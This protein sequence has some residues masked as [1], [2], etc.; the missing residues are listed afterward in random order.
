MRRW[1][2]V[3]A[4]VAFGIGAVLLGPGSYG[5]FGQ[6]SLSF[7]PNSAAAP[8]AR[9]SA[10]APVTPAP[11]RTTSPSCIHAGA[12]SRDNANVRPTLK[13]GPDDFGPPTGTSQFDLAGAKSELKFRLCGQ[14]ASH[15]YGVGPDERLFAAI[16]TV[17][18]G[19]NPNDHL[20]E[21]T[22]V[23]EVD[24]LVGR[25]IQWSQ[26]TLVTRTFAT[27][28]TELMVPGNFPKIYLVQGTDLPEQFLRVPARTTNG[29]IK[30]L[31]LRL[32]C[33]FQPYSDS[34][35]DFPAVPVAA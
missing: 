6:P 23:A 12:V 3:L 11:K 13:M 30:I 17:V 16:W 1:W 8:A 27:P 21:A 19:G 4:I 7:T 2:P 9:S 20:P 32:S 5:L 22:W 10:P 35:Q 25:D 24:Q 34:V 15:G 18:N 28:W 33:G 14:G 31:Y 29:Q 26:V